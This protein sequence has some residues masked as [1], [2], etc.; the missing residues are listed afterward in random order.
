MPRPAAAATHT[1]DSPAT[2]SSPCHRQQTHHYFRR[3]ASHTERDGL[4]IDKSNRRA[5]PC[6]RSHSFH[7]TSTPTH[8]RPISS[9]G[10]VPSPIRRVRRGEGTTQPTTSP[11]GASSTRTD[12]ARDG[13]Y[14]HVAS[15]R[16][17]IPGSPHPRPILVLFYTTTQAKR[18]SP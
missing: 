5:F 12:L 13:Q 6:T 8:R 14:L 11:Y 7:Y 1:S 9:P 15:T 18:V 10:T 2:P 16:N 4:L 17:D 3:C